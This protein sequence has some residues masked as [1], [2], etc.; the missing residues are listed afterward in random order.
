[1][2]SRIGWLPKGI[3]GLGK[4]AVYGP[5]RVPLPPARITAFMIHSPSIDLHSVVFNLEEIQVSLDPFDRVRESFFQRDPGLP[6]HDL[7]G[8]AVVCQEAL[9]LTADWSHPLFIRLDDH[10]ATDQLA[11]QVHQIADTDLTTASDIDHIADRPLAD[12]GGQEPCHGI[13]HIIEV[14]ERR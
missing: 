1:M 10:I 9:D 4:T 14:A 5:K 11:N 12:R 6:T 3:N 2:T 13:A 8:L 7:L